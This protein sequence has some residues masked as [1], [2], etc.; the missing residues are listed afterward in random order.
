[1]LNK[2]ILIG[3]LSVGALLVASTAGAA[4]AAKIER[5]VA[6]TLEVFA[7]GRGIWS[8]LSVEERRA[9]L[10]HMAVL[11]DDLYPTFRLFLFDGRSSFSMP[12]TIF[13]PYRAAVYAGGMYL[14]L[15]ATETVRA[16]TRHFDGLIRAAV[17][18]AHESVD[19]VSRLAAACAPSRQSD[20]PA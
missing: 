14:V 3:L 19:F 8:G 5:E 2:Q 18:N 17:V 1:M 7:Q 20:S 16:L 11:L 15:N 12:Y 4:S 10:R 13:G 9:Q 6:K